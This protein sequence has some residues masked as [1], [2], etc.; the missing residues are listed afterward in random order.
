MQVSLEPRRISTPGRG[1]LSF[2]IVL[3]IATLLSGY[4]RWAVSDFA[5]LKRDDSGIFMHIG[6]RLVAGDRLYKDVWDNKPPLIHYLNALGVWATPGSALGVFLICTL[7]GLITYFAISIGLRRRVDW[8]WLLIGNVLLV[9]AFFELAATPN[10]TEAF[11]MPL[12]GIALA[13]LVDEVFSGHYGR[14]ALA[15]GV[16]VGILFSL[17]PNN[18]AFGAIY[19]AVIV[20]G[21][22]NAIRD[23]VWTL[24]RF[25]GGFLIYMGAVFL[26]MAI[27]GS[28][29]D[30]WSAVFVAGRDYS[31]DNASIARLK[32]VV[33]GFLTLSHTYL[34]PAATAILISVGVY[35]R[36]IDS[37]YRNAVLACLAWSVVEI[38]ASSISGYAWRHYFLMWLVPMSAVVIFGLQGLVST[39]NIDEE[40]SNRSAPARPSVLLRVA[41][42]S[43]AISLAFVLLLQF[44]LSTRD[45]MAAGSDDIGLTLARKYAHKD[46]AFATWG[47][48]PRHFWFDFAHKPAAS[49][50]HAAGYTHM[51]AYR[52]LVERFLDDL[53]SH[54]PRIVL[55]HRSILPLFA[56]PD[57]NMP[58]DWF[59]PPAKFASWDDAEITSR[60]RSIAND[61][62]LAEERDGYCIYLRK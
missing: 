11:A 52:R 55:E 2:C 43:G 27:A 17:R 41:G 49:L 10:F 12:Q 28:Y 23:M 37:R 50:F 29:S 21:E 4:A 19:V 33:I 60:K 20:L 16:V 14:H 59:F 34:L 8:P 5:Q 58:L 7:S 42:V 31:G 1:A 36:K 57:E 32:A 13:L 35:W 25:A 54:H 6:Q 26:A 61:Y 24:V 48:M 40:L 3:F 62:V 38:I 47:A 18:A 22:R 39:A 9:Q 51:R 44:S 15:Q 46:D 56:K 30:F 53:E 45:A